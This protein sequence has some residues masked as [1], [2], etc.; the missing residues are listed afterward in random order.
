MRG[1]FA[2]LFGK[3]EPKALK[4]QHDR[5]HYV[6]GRVKPTGGVTKVTLE[7]DGVRAVGFAACSN[8]DNFNR[9]IGYQIALGRALKRLSS[10]LKEAAPNIR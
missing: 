8:E 1:R 5:R 9:R 3:I 7:F 6:D 2:E 10:S 4:V